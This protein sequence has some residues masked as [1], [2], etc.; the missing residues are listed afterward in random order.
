MPRKKAINPALQA[1]MD[2][3]EAE[4]N[5]SSHGS[6]LY[7]VVFRSEAKD[8]GCLCMRSVPVVGE[9]VIIDHQHYQVKGVQRHIYFPYPPSEGKRKGIL[10]VTPGSHGEESIVVVY[11][12]G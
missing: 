6:G 7:Q 4:R 1:E 10:A 3:W 9:W 5:S 2:K 12:V 8:F 11:V